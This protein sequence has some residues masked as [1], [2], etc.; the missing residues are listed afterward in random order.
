M[1]RLNAS[2]SCPLRALTVMIVAVT[3]CSFALSQTHVLSPSK[4][5]PTSV[6]P[7]SFRGSAQC[8]SEGN[9]Y[10]LVE[11]PESRTPFILRLGADH[12]PSAYGFNDNIQSDRYL[13]FFF[14]WGRMP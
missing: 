1:S 11:K 5:S 10:F 12:V 4:I 2:F 9:A 13:A 8:D 3:F 6:P 7:F 14:M